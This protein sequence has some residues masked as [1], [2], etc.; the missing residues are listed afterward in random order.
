MSNIIPNKTFLFVVYFLPLILNLN[1]I[2][3][4]QNPFM[5]KF[6]E[7][8]TADNI[9][10]LRFS[11][12]PDSVGINYSHFFAIQ[13]PQNMGEQELTYNQFDPP[14]YTC[15][16]ED[17][18]GNTYQLTA[19]KPDKGTSKS[20]VA[21]AYMAFC[22]LDEV[23]KKVK[24]GPE[25]K[26]T[27]TLKFGVKLSVQFIRGVGLFT[28]T[29][30]NPARVIIDSVPVIGTGGLYPDHT[31]LTLNRALN[32]EQAT[33]II[34]EGPLKG[35]STDFKKDTA[36]NGVSSDPSVAIFPYTSI[37]IN[38]IL[39]TGATTLIYSDD[40]ILALR[41]PSSVVS[42]PKSIS[43]EEFKFYEKIQPALTGTV[44]LVPVDS[45]DMYFVTGWTDNMVD[46][47]IFNIRC[48]D[49]K[50]SDYISSTAAAIEVY[51]FYKNTYSLF[52][53][54]RIKMIKITQA[55]V[56]A[57][58]NHPEYWD[59]WRN[60]AWP[61]K[62]VI[63]TS[64]D[65]PYG[66]YVSI[67]HTNALEG[68]NRVNFMPS[69]CDFSEWDP[70]KKSI[71]NSFGVRPNCYPLRTDYN[72]PGTSKVTGYY[73]SGFFFKVPVLKSG[74]DY[75]LTLWGM[76]DNCGG[77]Q[78]FDSNNPNF[79][80]K[81]YVQFSFILYIYKYIDA[82]AYNEDRLKFTSNIIFG[83]STEFT[84]GNKCLNNR[85]TFS[86][87]RP[88]YY[89]STNLLNYLTVN[90]IGNGNDNMI[91]REITDW[92]TTIQ[93]NPNSCDDGT[94]TCYGYD[95]VNNK[96]VENFIYSNSGKSIKDSFFMVNFKVSK[97]VNDLVFNVIPINYRNLL[98]DADP[99]GLAPGRLVWQ[100]PSKFFVKGDSWMG[101]NM[102][103]YAS[104]TT[105]IEGSTESTQT[106][107]LQ[108]TENLSNPSLKS[109]FI[110]A[111][112]GTIDPIFSNS[113]YSPGDKSPIR[114]VSSLYK[115]S[116]STEN[117]F[118]WLSDF[119]L[120]GGT[121]V[122]FSLYTSCFKWTLP[123]IKSLYANIDIQIMWNYATNYDVKTMGVPSKNIRLN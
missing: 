105:N 67:Q 11:F 63:N 4:S 10:K 33:L 121:Y 101:D 38:L 35:K 77:S 82:S 87:T 62:F 18:K 22:R 61:F 118:E 81:S 96:F 16:L 50:A 20:Q 41:F 91:L 115:G 3:D 92:S 89:D 24:V 117:K 2:P 30:N 74:V 49:L 7:T 103:C 47:R 79:K 25:Y 123:E 34:N 108:T 13:F 97:K 15:A 27:L 59:I 102:S 88:I 72:Y 75:S 83:K 90:L 107:L 68:I 19:V 106:Q 43:N 42:A 44:N 58:V 31:I 5:I 104:W 110:S 69:T 120:N 51:L 23:I 70:W 52:S 57:S 54:D 26:Y 64:I 6:P 45:K 78:F 12:H 122:I 9:L 55:I 39:R 17:N 111:Q 93:T 98:T 29:T 95:V 40:T 76:A 73:G 80:D 28:C 119:K 56:K 100:F 48:N 109:N 114:L 94:T 66:G 32:I 65:F 85:I 116:V 99:S 84:M 14:V 8:L 46:N 112:A 1:L 21:E 53:Y 113:S 37:T 60:G 36:G 71:D 86:N